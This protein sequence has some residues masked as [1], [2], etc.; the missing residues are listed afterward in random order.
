MK[1]N[2]HEPYERSESAQSGVGPYTTRTGA[3]AWQSFLVAYF[4][5]NVK[6]TDRD[7]GEKRERG[8]KDIQRGKAREEERGGKERKRKKEKNEHSK[9]E[10]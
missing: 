4:I 2:H 8:R 1:Y 6:E 3:S 10:K 7:R 9:K 5:E